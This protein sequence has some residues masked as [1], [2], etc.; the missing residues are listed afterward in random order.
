MVY[1]RN[2]HSISYQVLGSIFIGLKNARCG[3]ELHA[4]N[5]YHKRFNYDK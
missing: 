5:E 2:V 4:E 3:S 1:L